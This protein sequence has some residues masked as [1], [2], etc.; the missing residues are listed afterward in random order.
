MKGI[1]SFEMV[2]NLSKVYVKRS[3]GR[4][5]LAEVLKVLPEGC[6]VVFSVNNK[7][8]LKSVRSIDDISIPTWQHN[9]MLLIMHYS[10][11]FLGILRSIIL[12][13]I[14]LF[15]YLLRLA[16]FKRVAIFIFIFCT[17]LSLKN[18]HERRLE[19]AA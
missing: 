13:P 6:D 12:C 14:V 7:K 10:R 9:L 1:N 5:E 16:T 17:L 8:L 3:D 19:V 2:K 18:V 4:W 11:A 15:G